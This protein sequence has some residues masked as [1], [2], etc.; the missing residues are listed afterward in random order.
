MK[1][2]KVIEE[3]KRNGFITERQI[4]LLKNRTNRGEIIE[5]YHDLE[6]IPITPEQTEK[7]IKFLLNLYKTPTGKIRKRN[8]FSDWQ[9][10]VLETFVEF[11][12]V[13]FYNNSSNGFVINNYPIYS[14][15]G[16]DGDFEYYYDLCNGT[17]NIL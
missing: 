1:T 8:P 7:G 2:E 11:A 17:I 15:C 5:R 4:N 9:A 12:F 16:A 3:I 14:V 10:E 6:Y 13:G